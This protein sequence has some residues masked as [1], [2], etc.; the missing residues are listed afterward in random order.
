MMKA[1]VGSSW[2]VTGRSSATV[3]AGPIP[4]STPMAVPTVTPSA[5][6]NRFT[7]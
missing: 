4:G 1:A 6:Q 7:G 2:A 5:D 3:S